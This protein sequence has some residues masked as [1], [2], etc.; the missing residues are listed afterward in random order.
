MNEPSTRRDFLKLGI[1]GGVSAALAP[2]LADGDRSAGQDKRATSAVPFVA[3]PI[4]RVRIGFVG[5]GGMGTVHV[6]NLVRI[7]G[8]DIRAVCDIVEEKVQRAQNIVE[9]AGLARPKGYSRGPR[10]FERM[11]HEEELDLVYTATPWELHVPV[12]VAA[13]TR[14]NHAAKAK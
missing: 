7:E 13:M 9:Q 6:N 2:T 12:R 1:A 10:D 14:G 5:V 11:C 4:E 8:A 3:P